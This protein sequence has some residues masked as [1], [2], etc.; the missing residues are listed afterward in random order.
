[1]LR[2]FETPKSKQKKLKFY[3]GIGGNGYQQNIPFQKLDIF[4]PF[5]RISFF[6]CVFQRNF[7]QERHF[8][9]VAVILFLP[10]SQEFFAGIPVGQD[11][12]I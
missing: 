8:E 3:V 11:S 1:M 4:D 2:D 7:S 10:I 9:G 6:C 12:C 5:P